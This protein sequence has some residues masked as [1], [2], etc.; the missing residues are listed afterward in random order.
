L[1]QWIAARETGK[2]THLEAVGSL[3]F[4]ISSRTQREAGK[5]RQQANAGKAKFKVR[6]ILSSPLSFSLSL[7]LLRLCDIRPARLAWRRRKKPT[8]PSCAQ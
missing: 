5:E 3:V 8:L 7:T 1:E 6:R 4:L 2:K